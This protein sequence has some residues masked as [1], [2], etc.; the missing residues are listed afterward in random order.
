MI[1]ELEQRMYALV[2]RDDDSDWGDVQHRVRRLAGRRRPSRRLLLVAAAA[3]LLGAA[4]APALAIERGL[5]PW[6]RGEPAPHDVTEK[7]TR[8]SDDFLRTRPQFADSPLGQLDTSAIR[9]VVALDTPVG[10]LRLWAVPSETGDACMYTQIGSRGRGL[11]CPHPSAEW[12]LSFGWGPISKSGY[13]LLEG[14]AH[15]DV[16]WLGIRFTDGSVEPVPFV[17]RYFVSIVGGDRKPAELISRR[18]VD[19]G[20]IESSLPL[21]PV[22]R[23]RPAGG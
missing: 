18:R 3:I 16:A 22:D 23:P 2:D 17:D 9:G 21:P 6:F 12:P 19:G 11:H 15:S 8:L 7:L 4:V 1:G 10:V 20:E 5:L 13:G 14:R